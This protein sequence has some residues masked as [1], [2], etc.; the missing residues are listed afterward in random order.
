MVHDRETYGR[1]EDRTL[2]RDAFRGELAEVIDDTPRRREERAPEP[3]ASERVEPAARPASAPVEAPERAPTRAAPQ[4]RADR[5]RACDDED[6]GARHFAPLPPRVAPRSNEIDDPV[7]WVMCAH[8]LGVPILEIADVV[9]KV[10]ETLIDRG[11]IESYPTESYQSAM[12]LLRAARYL[13]TSGS[14]DETALECLR[15]ATAELTE[16]VC[17]FGWTINA[18]AA[19]DDEPGEV[20]LCL[21]RVVLSIAEPIF[22]ARWPHVAAAM[23]ATVPASVPRAGVEPQLA[24]DR[25]VI[26]LALRTTRV[27]DALSEVLTAAL[28]TG[29]P[30]TRGAVQVA[31]ASTRVV[32]AMH[33]AL[34]ALAA[35]EE[36]VDNVEPDDA[37]PGVTGE[38]VARALQSP[39]VVG[40]VLLAM[41]DA[42][43]DLDAEKS[44]GAGARDSDA[45]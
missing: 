12:G 36:R 31:L 42:R 2:R 28:A 35:G 15:H 37:L 7:A 25:E 1:G 26:E 20:P 10:L 21:L 38:L 32:E 19:L 39:S 14:N 29:H 30:T 23:D 11:P 3:R 33:S 16:L 44:E 40:A 27:V 45:L 18:I 13:G 5:P 8:E 41:G 34:E 4:R 9:R 43:E 24:I 6:D 22:R 17:P